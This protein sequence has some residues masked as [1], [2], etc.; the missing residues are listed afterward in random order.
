MW[1]LS[2][3]RME[4]QERI[5]KLMGTSS[6]SSSEASS[7]STDAKDDGLT[8]EQKQKKKEFE[9]ENTK[10]WA[11]KDELK[12]VKNKYLR[13]ML[14]ENGQSD[15]GGETLLID[16]CALGM[17]FGALPECPNKDCEDGYYTFSGGHFK[18]KYVLWFWLTI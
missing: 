7:S 17:M 8:E 9:E 14:T 18:C 5:Q 1:G 12:K 11:I 3:I 15:K 13:E 2:S 16:R 6:G 10:I 4:D